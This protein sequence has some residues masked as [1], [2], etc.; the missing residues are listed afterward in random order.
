MTPK[1]SVII[2]VYNA[3]S[4]IR[5]S[6]NSVIGQTLQDIEIICVDDGST[7]SSLDILREYSDVHNNI[8]VLEQKNQY[9]GVARNYGVTQSIGEYLYFLDSDDILYEDALEKLY[10]VITDKKVDIVRGKSRA[11]DNQSN[12][13]VYN[14]RYELEKVEEQVFNE[15]L[16]FHEHSTS[17]MSGSV[18]PWAGMCRRNFIVNNKIEFPPLK[19][20]NDRAFFIE[21]VMK[22][23]GVVITDVYIQ[24]HRMNNESSL[25]GNRFKNFQCH[26]DSYEYILERIDR[27][28]ASELLKE[29]LNAEL[30]DLAIWFEKGVL[31]E[32][33]SDI[34]NIFTTYV[35]KMDRT[36]WD[37]D[38]NSQE[39]FKKIRRTINSL[40][41]IKVSVIIPVF[42][43]EKYI[44]ESLETVRNQ[45]LDEIEIICVDDGSTDKS[46][47]ILREIE[48]EDDRLQVLT[49]EN[50]G[51]SVAR[52]KGLSIAKGEYLSILDADDIF[53]LN[54][55]EKAYL[56]AKSC[57]ADMVVFR[58]DH[59]LQEEDKFEDTLWTLKAEQMPD[60]E[61]F[62][63]KEVESN[64]FRSVIGW[65]WDKL[66]KRAFIEKENIRFQEIK[67]HNDLL[68][69]Y[70][71]YVTS[72]RVTIID[73]VLVHQRKYA[74]SLSAKCIAWWCVYDS[75]KALEKFLQ[76]K[77]LYE[78][79]QQ[80]YVNYVLHLFYHML[81]RLNAEDYA[82]AYEKMGYKWLEDLRI[83]EHEKAYYYNPNEY[84]KAVKIKADALKQL[85]IK[86]YYLAIKGLFLCVKEHGIHYTIG[87]IKIK[88]YQKMK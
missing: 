56:Q 50:S 33:S 63:P 41:E 29:I 51:A 11:F 25:V 38:I 88:I 31:T 87:R 13:Y 47:A 70:G 44:K 42:N 14:Q 60:K 10:T 5:E 9:A 15:I 21:S 78:C 28:S 40:R 19:C 62:S 4:Y 58:A 22:A 81:G 57:D 65:S 26:I 83:F 20:V 55:L 72:D 64:I 32:F 52:N 39:W 69:V 73:E 75:V 1:V 82:N 77:E 79:Y 66:F 36:P 30:Y 74:E 84:D 61:Y 34:K 53:E 37:G 67:L 16:N 6:L 54:M 7:D 18:A 80:D 24:R 59:Y 3:E 2:P 48:L 43:S 12:E 45:T 71:A 85:G 17:I 76:E 46:L 35:K 23:Q 8:K 27:E 68:F 49:Q 86:R